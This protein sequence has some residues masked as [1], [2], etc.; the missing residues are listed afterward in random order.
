LII[1]M[2]EFLIFFL[3]SLGFN[4]FFIVYIVLERKKSKKENLNR[5]KVLKQVLDGNYNAR[6][7]NKGNKTE[8]IDFF[9]NDLIEKLQR[10]NYNMISNE[11]RIKQQLSNIA[12]DL[13]TPLTSIIGYLDAIK[14]NVASNTKEFEKY[15]DIVY[16]KAKEMKRFSEEI[17]EY[18]RI[19][20]GDYKIDPENFDVVEELKSVIVAFVPKINES[21]I[22][23]E[24]IIPDK[25]I[26]INFD[27]NSFNRITSNLINNAL[28]HGSEGK[29]LGIFLERSDK[30][31]TIEIKDK[32]NGI[33]ENKIDHIFNRLFK[34]DD[35][36]KKQN[37]SYGLGLAITKSLVKANESN[38]EVISS[39]ESTSFILTIYF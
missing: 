38:I 9:I 29:Y 3:V 30:L 19:E 37:S 35:S 32:G 15:F 5:I 23:P 16:D 1:A 21:G 2:N 27:R 24:I 25:E 22:V 6:I 4:I 13:R 33:P 26:I 17:F 31:L 10:I 14:N 18:T 11:E 39:D 8:S 20:A 28:Q 7:L 12:H 34:A 36:R